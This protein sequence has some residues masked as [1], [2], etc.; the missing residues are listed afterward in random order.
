MKLIAQ[1]CVSCRLL[2][3]RGLSRK[4]KLLRAFNSV[5]MNALTV[6]QATILPELAMPREIKFFIA[7]GCVGYVGVAIFAFLIFVYH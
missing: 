4:R 1:G 7:F 3:G 5:T 6:I 2:A